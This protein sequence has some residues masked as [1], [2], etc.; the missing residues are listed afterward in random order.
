VKYLVFGAAG[1]I[2]GVLVR[3][4]LSAG[5]EVIASV[6]ERHVRVEEELSEAG[7]QVA[8]V[9]DVSDLDQ[10]KAFAARFAGERAFD[11]IVYA[12][13]HCPPK[14]FPE[15]I[16]HP[17]SQLPLAEYLHEINM[18]QIGPLVVFQQMAGCVADGGCFV[19]MSSAITRLKGKPFP[20]FLH[21]HHHAGVIGAG[22]WLVDGMREDPMVA[23][24]GIKIHRIA[25]AAVN[26][27]FHDIEPRVPKMVPIATV[28]ERIVFA[29]GSPVVVDEQL[30]P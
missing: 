1:S 3:Q 17:L 20:S 8:A 26:T 11:G 15:A 5:H 9:D 14:G 12:V 28:A 25:P 18:H 16:K 21:A 29:L 2:G 13:G 22:D 30:V 23:K 10:V 19:F 6:R 24:R 4:L 7:A 27:P